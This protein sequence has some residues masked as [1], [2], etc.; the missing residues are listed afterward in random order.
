VVV[1][2]VVAIGCSS[3]SSSSSSLKRPVNTKQ[4]RMFKKRHQKHV[5]HHLIMNLEHHGIITEMRGE[6]TVGEAGNDAKFLI[7]S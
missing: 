4:R 1:L 3:T 2:V 5:N 7:S 6:G